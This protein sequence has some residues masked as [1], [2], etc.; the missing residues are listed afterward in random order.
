MQ[1]HV[2]LADNPDYRA[3]YAAMMRLREYARRAGW[4]IP[5]E[6]R[7]VA[8]ILWLERSAVVAQR[9]AGHILEVLDQGLH[10][11][12]WYLGRADALRDILGEQQQPEQAEG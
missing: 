7:I 6:R 5:P 10:P 9:D 3:G 1:K 8:E 12:A 11:A 4:P 2:D